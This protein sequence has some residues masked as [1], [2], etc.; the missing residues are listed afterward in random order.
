M[1]K[2]MENVKITKGSRG[3]LD[4]SHYDVPFLLINSP[5]IASPYEWGI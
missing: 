3:G 1:Y 5:E 4:P 2:D